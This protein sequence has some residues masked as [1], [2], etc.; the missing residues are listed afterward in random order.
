MAL[1]QQLR[2]SLR[3]DDLARARAVFDHTR[4]YRVNLKVENIKVNGDQAEVTGRR[5]DVVVTSN[6]ERI[7]TPDKFR[8]RLK[9]A[10][11]RWTIEAIR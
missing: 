6:G 10:D 4:S 9:R 5:E 11:N 3:G 7:V 2:P 1:L 8:F